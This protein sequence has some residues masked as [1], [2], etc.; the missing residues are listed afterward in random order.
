MRRK[1]GAAGMYGNLEG[2]HKGS[3]KEVGDSVNAFAVIIMPLP[4][5]FKVIPY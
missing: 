5:C 1:V 4:K 3:R 2:N